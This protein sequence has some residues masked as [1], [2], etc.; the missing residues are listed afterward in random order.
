M[1]AGLLLYGGRTIVVDATL[2][3][4]LTGSGMWR[5]NGHDEDGASFAQATRDKH[6]KYPELLSQGLRVHFVV[7]A[8]E[9][10]GRACE[11]LID[12]VRQAAR[13]KAT[14][15]APKL[16]GSMRT[17]LTRRFWS[18]L[19]VATQRAVAQCAS[20]QFDINRAAQFPVPDLESL[21]SHPEAPDV[22][23]LP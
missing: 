5:Y 8:A 6:H 21:L 2:R 16:R 14:Q 11:A 13:H 3:S 23:R 18:I 9:V 15:F 20:E 1:A 22:S 12:L 10:G 7:A 4:P 17:V 19:S